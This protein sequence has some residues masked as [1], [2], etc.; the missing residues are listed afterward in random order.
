VASFTYSNSAPPLAVKFVST[1]KNAVSYL[2]DFDNGSKSTNK[3]PVAVF[4]WARIYNVCLTIT[5]SCGLPFTS[6]KSVDLTKFDVEELEWI[7]SIEVYPNP[8][9]GHLKI[10]THQNN[11]NQAK[12]QVIDIKGQILLEA[13]FESGQTTQNLNLEH[14]PAGLYLL[15]VSTGE[16]ARNIKISKE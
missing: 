16:V 8:T 5:D 14:L 15:K 4:G 1:S 6:C 2:W 9:N 12:L 10:E 13:P 3:N 11:S 7:K